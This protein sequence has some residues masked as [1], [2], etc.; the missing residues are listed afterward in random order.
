MR[1]TSWSRITAAG[2]A[3][4]SRRELLSSAAPRVR[5]RRR[6]SRRSPTTGSSPTATRAPWWLPMGRS[7]G[8]AYRAS[9]PP[10]CSAVCST[11]GPAPSASGP[12]GSTC[13]R[14]A[15]MS[16]G[17]NTLATTWH[18]RTGWVLVRD[19]LTIGPRHGDDTV[20]PH[21]RPPP[22][23]DAD[24]LLV[25]TALCLEGRVEMELTCEPSFDY[26]RHPG[27][28]VFGRGRPSCRRRRRRRPDHQVAVRHEPRDRGQLG[29]GPAHP[30]R[31][32]PGVLLALLGRGPRVAERPR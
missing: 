4:G 6:P 19:A 29:A 5:R 30:A 28:V 3:P 12:S 20:T 24:H 14:R 32:R 31:G 9:T 26:G 15:S 18:T 21:T 16:P 10:A 25:R 13:R 27:H 8:S 11:A 7:I 22:D 2:T 23:E 1:P 17:T